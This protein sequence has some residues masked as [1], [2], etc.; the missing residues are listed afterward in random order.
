MS[1]GK[2]VAGGKKVVETV[3]DIIYERRI[4]KI[5]KERF[6]TKILRLR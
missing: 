3:L 1:L 4:H 6:F 5:K 2:D